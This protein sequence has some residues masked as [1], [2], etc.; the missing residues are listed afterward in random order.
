MIYG[1]SIL[2][3]PQLRLFLII[4]FRL[5]D[6]FYVEQTGNYDEYNGEY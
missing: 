3:K 1:K 2:K 5:L 4:Y 6:V